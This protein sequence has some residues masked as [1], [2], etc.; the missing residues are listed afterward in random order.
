M[1]AS[2]TPGVQSIVLTEAGQ[3]CVA[4]TP[5]LVEIQMYQVVGQRSNTTVDCLYRTAVG[6]GVAR[7]TQTFVDNGSAIDGLRIRSS[8]GQVSGRMQVIQHA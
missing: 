4:T 3:D 1:I 6:A 8:S 5:V 2:I 7:K